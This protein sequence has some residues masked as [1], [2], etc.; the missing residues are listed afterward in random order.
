VDLTTGTTTE[1]ANALGDNTTM[2]A[3]GYNTLDNYL[4]AYQPS[5]STILQ[6]SA[7][8]T[9]TTVDAD[10]PPSGSYVG[11]ID[12]NGHYWVAV[13]G[14]TSWAEIDLAPGSATYGK[15]L[16]S[17][18]ATAPGNYAVADWVYIP[19]AGEYLYSIGSIA[20]SS[21]TALLRFD[22]STHEWETVA[23]FGALGVVGVGAMYGMN[24]GTLY[25]SENGNGQI[26]QF[27]ISGETPFMV[28]QGPS[29]GNNDGARCVLNLLA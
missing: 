29:S 16:S 11:D 15:T 22:M 18:T 13:G 8:G 26:W 17:G 23:D 10:A 4:Y 3:M 7:D 21:E 24:N 19:S 2:N 27:P 1:I 6:I 14:A 25:G 12:S 28:S 5:T 9:T 20:S